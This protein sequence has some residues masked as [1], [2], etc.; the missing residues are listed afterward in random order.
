M[1]PKGLSHACETKICRF[2]CLV[3][4]GVSIVN[5]RSSTH[6]IVLDSW[7]SCCIHWF[8]CTQLV[9]CG[10]KIFH[11]MY[12]ICK[13]CTRTFDWYDF[14]WVDEILFHTLWHTLTFSGNGFEKMNT[15]NCCTITSKLLHKLLTIVAHQKENKQITHSIVPYHPDQLTC[16]TSTYETQC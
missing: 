10:M 11:M 7:L 13:W 3:S 16:K 5:K 8:V 15:S 9:L 12:M 2:G 4:S 6:V 14:D 1:Q